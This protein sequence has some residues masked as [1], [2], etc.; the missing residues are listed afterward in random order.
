MQLHMMLYVAS[1]SG[2]QNSLSIL[3]YLSLQPAG[4]KGLILYAAAVAAAA[5]AAGLAV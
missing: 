5:A 2:T 4:Y 1:R 3:V